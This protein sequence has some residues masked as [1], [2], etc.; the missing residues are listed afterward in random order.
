[1]AAVIPAKQWPTSDRGWQ[2]PYDVVF[3]ISEPGCGARRV[4]MALVTIPPGGGNQCH[5]HA[6]T[7]ALG[8]VVEG[9][10]RNGLG[11]EGEVKDLT[12]RDFWHF[13]RN[14][15][16]WSRNLSGTEPCVMVSAYMGVGRLDE[17]QTT[18][19]D[20]LRAPWLPKAPDRLPDPGHRGGRVHSTIR[21][22]I[23]VPVEANSRTGIGTQWAMTS[24]SSEVEFGMSLLQTYA[25]GASSGWRTLVQAE[26]AMFLLRGELSLEVGESAVEHL[27]A[28]S[29]SFIHIPPGERL[30]IEN[31]G[32][33]EAE[34]YIVAA[35]V[36]HKNELTVS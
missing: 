35:G 2:P 6:S 5:V 17:T 8:F 21:R 23:E 14:E 11:Y 16:H 10:F 20:P 25:P 33:R 26:L 22:G 19:Y 9:S 4:M 1:M 7:E 29:G 24:T 32:A 30:R 36:R 28:H 27:E 15:P 3:G 13:A 12:P 18:Y 34:A 31:R